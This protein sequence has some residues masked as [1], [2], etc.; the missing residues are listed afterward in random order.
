MYTQNNGLPMSEL[1]GILDLGPCKKTIENYL[2]TSVS[3]ETTLL[4]SQ[5][6]FIKTS[7]DLSHG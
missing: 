2:I 4:K 1:S 7:F 6:K 3:F 5:Y